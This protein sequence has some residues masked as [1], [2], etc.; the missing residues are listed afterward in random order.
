[1]HF[2]FIFLAHGSGS[3]KS[4]NPDPQHW[5]ADFMVSDLAVDSVTGVADYDLSDELAD[6]IDGDLPGTGSC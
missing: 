4:L 3:T 6:Y 1:V 5:L 2:F